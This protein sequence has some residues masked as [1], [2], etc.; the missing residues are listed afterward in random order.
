MP[1]QSLHVRCWGMN[2]PSS[3]KLRC[4]KMTHSDR[5]LIRFAAT[6][7][8]QR[9]IFPT[10]QCSIIDL[11]GRVLCIGIYGSGVKSDGAF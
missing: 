8:G 11:G 6:H 5:L 4:L 9:A 10:C 7:H 3:E 1:M 2:R